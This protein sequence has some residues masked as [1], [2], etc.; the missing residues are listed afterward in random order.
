MSSNKDAVPHTDPRV[1]DE[2]YE[3]WSELPQNEESWVKRAQDV[4]DVLAK[5]A[6]LR[7][8]ENK[9]PKAEVALLKH[10]GLLKILGPRKFGGGEQPWSVGYKAIREVAKG[11]GYVLSRKRPQNYRN[12]NFS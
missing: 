7:D 6:G 4:A 9:S 10:S 2:Y 3:K 8:R 12:L 1:Y 11:D 5:D